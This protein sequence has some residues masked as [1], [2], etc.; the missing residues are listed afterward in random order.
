MDNINGLF[1]ISY[2][3]I[4]IIIYFLK[5]NWEMSYFSI[6]IFCVWVFQGGTLCLVFIQSH[7]FFKNHVMFKD[8]SDKRIKCEEFIKLFDIFPL[9]D[10]NKSDGD[11]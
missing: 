4:I 5:L 6:N 3:I 7:V 1:C 9:F 8:D 2:Q 10:S 11:R